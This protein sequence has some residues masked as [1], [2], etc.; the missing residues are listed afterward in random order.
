M[1]KHILIVARWPLGGIRT[2]MRYMFAHF[3]VGYRLTL[4][5][6]A[7]QEDAALKADADEYGARLLLVQATSTC[8]FAFEILKELHRHRYNLILSQGFVS[9][10]AIYP[11]NFFSRVPHIL[12][13]HGIVESQYL[14]G[15]LGFLKRWFLGRVLSGVTVLYGVS[16]D[17][18]EHLYHEYPR[19]RDDGPQSLVILNGIEPATFDLLPEYPLHLRAHLGIADTTFLFG[20]F[21]RFMPQK[22]F[23]LLINAVDQLRSEQYGYDFAVVAVGSGDYIREYQ[24]AIN[25]KKLESYFYFL[26]FQPMVHQLYP[27][28]DTVII[29]SRWE[30]CP[31]L[32]MEALCMGT[33]IIASDCMGLR[34]VVTDTPAFVFPA[35]NTEQ[36]VDKMR[37][38]L[39]DNMLDVFKEFMAIARRRFDV[40]N[41]AQR[42]TGFIGELLSKVVCKK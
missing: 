26:P 5:A 12:T 38:C 10:V 11:A 23:D 21:G 40:A 35:E 3:P 17:I 22:G 27:Q 13:I 31:L 7:T 30:A 8:A 34:E 33:P 41:S 32:P 15:R 20:F 9:A 18:L 14:E 29:P 39:Q 1:D 4:L 2:Y 25:N 37:S 6:A 19:L 16:F 28:V 36:L 24:I 42:L